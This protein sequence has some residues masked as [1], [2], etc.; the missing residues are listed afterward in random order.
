MARSIRSQTSQHS[1]TVWLGLAALS[2]VEIFASLTCITVLGAAELLPLAFNRLLA[3]ELTG[4][5]TAGR[6]RSS[7]RHRPFGAKYPAK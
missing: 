3:L 2:G 4:A 7:A 1:M 6:E 5:Q